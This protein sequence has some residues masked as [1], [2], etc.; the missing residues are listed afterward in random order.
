MPRLSTRSSAFLYFPNTVIRPAHSRS[1]SRFTQKRKHERD[2]L[3]SNQVLGWQ[4]SKIWTHF[5]SSEISQ[6]IFHDVNFASIWHSPSV[7][8][9]CHYTRLYFEHTDGFCGFHKTWRNYEPRVSLARQ[10]GAVAAHYTYAR[11]HVRLL[12]CST[13]VILN[14]S[15]EDNT[16]LWRLFLCNITTV[17]EQLLNCTS[18]G[19]YY[20]IL[21]LWWWKITGTF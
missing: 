20:F 2:I 8:S 12:S 10:I 9:C 4:I 5:N 7:R 1:N 6:Q 18:Q 11:F 16:V 15:D 3:T 21:L 17:I 14:V 19:H 13:A